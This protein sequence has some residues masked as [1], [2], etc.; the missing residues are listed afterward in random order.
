MNGRQR[1][2]YIQ[3]SG[4][5][6]SIRRSQDFREKVLSQI[7]HTLQHL[8]CIHLRGAD[9]AGAMIWMWNACQWLLCLNT[10][11]PVRVLKGCET[12]KRQKLAGRSGLLEAFLNFWAQF[13]FPFALCFLTTN[14]MWSTAFCF[15]GHFFY[16]LLEY[17]PWNC[18]PE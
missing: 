10:W 14:T 6:I 7:F 9:S 18:Q 8:L 12:F 4:T 13:P 2:R 3:P 17:I 16:A 5:V 15:G 11:A 1:A